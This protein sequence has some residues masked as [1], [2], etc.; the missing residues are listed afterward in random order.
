MSVTVDSTVETVAEWSAR[1]TREFCT[2]LGLGN[3]KSKDLTLLTIA[4]AEVATREARNN[5]GFAGRVRSAFQELMVSAPK[6]GKRKK[7]DI[8]ETLVPIG[9]VD[10]SRLRPSGAIDPFAVYEGYGEAQTRRVLND[11]TLE[12]LKQSAAIVEKRNPGAKPAKRTAKAPLV[13]Y[14]M[15]HVTGGRS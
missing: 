8:F 3:V 15:E 10:L 7:P 11:E 4:L 6:A 13:A 5:S 2:A 9:P 12:N 1:A 14:I